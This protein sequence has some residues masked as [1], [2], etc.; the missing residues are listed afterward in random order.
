MDHQ[1]L[2]SHELMD[3]FSRQLSQD[4]SARCTWPGH[5]DGLFNT[6][7]AQ[8]INIIKNRNGLNAAVFHCMVGCIDQAA[9]NLNFL[10]RPCSSFA[11]WMRVWAVSDASAESRLVCVLRLRMVSRLQATCSVARACSSDDAAMD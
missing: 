1:T 11:R 5:L 8:Q 4:D 10:I 2:S 3:I 7:I 9:A 6:S